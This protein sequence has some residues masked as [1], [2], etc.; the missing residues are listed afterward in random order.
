MKG[1]EN[2]ACLI[3]LHYLPG[4]RY[5]QLFFQYDTVHIER[6]EHY[7]KRSYRNRC[8]IGSA[9]GAE[10]L[11]VPLIKGKHQQQPV[12]EVA[13]AYY[14]PWY[15]KHWH[16]I[17]TSYGRSAFFEHYAEEIHTLLYSKPKTLYG[18]NVALL[19]WLLKKLQA[20]GI[21]VETTDFETA[22]T[23][24]LK[25][26]R[27][28]ITLSKDDILPGY[29]QAF[30]DRIGFLSNLSALDLLMHLGP[31]SYHYLDALSMQN[32]V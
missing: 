29:P 14:E 3:E 5:L 22:P 10:V 8:H 12:H 31:E 26:L 7:Q 15:A 17:Q 13:I 11:S 23:G 4:I 1:D 32:K 25:D 21:L 19:K 16:A 9:Q 6:H 20:P 30:M 28:T 18:L 24:L 27:N 2:T